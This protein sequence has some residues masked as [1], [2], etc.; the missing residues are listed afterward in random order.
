MQITSCS[1]GKEEGS[2]VGHITNRLL[3]IL[4]R[5]SLF[6]FETRSCSIQE[7]LIT[8]NSSRLFDSSSNT[9][10]P[11]SLRQDRCLCTADVK[12][13]SISYSV[14]SSQGEKGD[15]GEQGIPVSS[16]TTPSLPPAIAPSSGLLLER[17]G[18]LWSQPLCSCTLLYVRRHHGYTVHLI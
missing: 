7:L 2:Q 14:Y 3:K 4:E 17:W 5:Q 10:L 18:V 16:T 9:F 6:A 12:D 13:K 15:E 1:D 11:C 8:R